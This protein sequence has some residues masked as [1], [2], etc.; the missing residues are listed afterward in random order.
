[1][2]KAYLAELS[3]GRKIKMD[4]EEVPKLMQ[5]IATG[6]AV[7][8]KQGIITNPNHVVDIVLD[9]D[10]ISANTNNVFDPQ[11][12]RQGKITEIRELT[13]EF[14]DLRAAI[15]SRRR[16]Q[17]TLPHGNTDSNTGA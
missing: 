5:A 2:N 15:E 4:P 7:V 10:R 16:D 11:T 6:A 1:M 3:T 12:L 17:K 13:D 14:S 9:M 8:L